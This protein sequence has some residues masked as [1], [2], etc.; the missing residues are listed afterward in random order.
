MSVYTP[1]SH[2][3]TITGS[4]GGLSDSTPLILTLLNPC[5]DATLNY[6]RALVP[7]S[8]DNV[9]SQILGES[10]LTLNINESELYEQAFEAPDCGSV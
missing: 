5:D 6:V 2:T 3:V 10:E 7:G 8:I 4:L 9:Y 1:G